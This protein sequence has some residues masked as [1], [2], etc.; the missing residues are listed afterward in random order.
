MTIPASISTVTVVGTYVDIIGNPVRGSIVFKPQVVLK[1]KTA[2]VIIMPSNIEKVFDANGSFS[3]ILPCTDDPDGTPTSFIYTVTENFSGGRVF[4]IALPIAVAGTTQN[5]ADILPAVALSE[6]LSY[7]TLAQYT[8]L[9]ARYSTAEGIRAVVI[10][11]PTHVAN[12]LAYR[13]ATALAV[14][15]SLYGN[16]FSMM[17]MGI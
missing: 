16:S 14:Q 1:E 5:M 7:V 10:T 9:S 17:A 2:N 11:S 6:S 15:A 12:A 3:I 13:D 8:A 4:D